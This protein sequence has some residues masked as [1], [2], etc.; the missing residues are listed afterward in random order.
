MPAFNINTGYVILG[1]SP[2]SHNIR[3][4]SDHLFCIEGDWF[5]VPLV[6][7]GHIQWPK[8][9]IPMNQFKEL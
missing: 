5:W 1:A 2:I 6:T 7:N 3:S 4:H 8:Q 9:M